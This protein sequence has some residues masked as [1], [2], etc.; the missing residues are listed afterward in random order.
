MVII[1]N[2]DTQLINIDHL[3]LTMSRQQMEKSAFLSIVVLLVSTGMLFKIF[4]WKYIWFRAVK[5]INRD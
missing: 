1:Y 2:M 3:N 5:S 4:V